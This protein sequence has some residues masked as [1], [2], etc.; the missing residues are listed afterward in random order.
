MQEFHTDTLGSKFIKNLLKSTPLPI[1]PSINRGDYTI[2]GHN[3]YYD[4]KIIKSTASKE[5]SQNYSVIADV[6]IES[7]FIPY[8]SRYSYYDTETHETLGK[9]LDYYKSTTGIDLRPLYNCFSDRYNDKFIY[10]AVYQINNG[11]SDKKYVFKQE[12]N[13]NSNIKVIMVPIKFDRIYTIAIDSSSEVIMRPFFYNN[14]EILE[15]LSSK[16]NNFKCATDY[17]TLINSVPDLDIEADNF[18]EK[19]KPCILSKMFFNKPNL[20]GVFLNDDSLTTSEKDILKSNEKYL[21]LFIQLQKT[22]KSSIVILEGNYINRNIKNIINFD[23]YM[24]DESSSKL[25][26]NLLERNN[27][28]YF[29]FLSSNLDNSYTQFKETAIIKALDSIEKDKSTSYLFS[30]PS[31]LKLNTQKSYAFSDRLLEYLVHNVITSQ[32][33]LSGNVITVN[34][35]LGI[36]NSQ[37]FPEPE[38]SK[39]TQLRVFLDMIDKNIDDI[40]G[41][42]DKDTE[43]ILGGW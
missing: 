29:N 7:T 1:Y 25:T 30:F 20:F 31:L 28:N 37:N 15:N 10:K 14:G 32:D 26:K 21:Y 6:D 12:S 19:S 22:N 42:V 40:N 41:Y 11:I 18:K 34:N 2:L 24:Y 8:D 43:E 13:L 27:N 39:T 36:F 17:S 16:L 35:R 23:K 38:W 3:Y 4:G 9:Y 33:D 5:L